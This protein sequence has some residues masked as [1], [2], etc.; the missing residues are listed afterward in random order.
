MLTWNEMLCEGP[1]EYEIGTP[2][3]EEK[4]ANFLKESF[5]VAKQYYHEK[6]IAELTKLKDLSSYDEIN[7]WFEYDLFCHVNMIAAI[8]HLKQL[9]YQ[10]SLFLISSRRVDK[11]GDIQ[12]LSQLNKKQLLEQYAHKISLTLDDVEHANTLWK[13]YNGDDH[14]QF[15]KYLT[16]SSSFPY[17]TNCISAHLK[18]F[19][20]THNGLNLLEVHTLNMIEQRQIKSKHHLLG[21][22]LKY[23]GYYGFG[24][25]QLKAMINK[26]DFLFAIEGD[27]LTLNKKG[28][29]ALEKQGNFFKELK[30]D[31]QFG[32]S[33]KY[34]YVYDINDRVLNKNKN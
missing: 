33:K 34:N 2:T 29:R 19:P 7:L 25:I 4:R 20:S 28:K 5:D 10:K 26:L 8:S 15:K 3:F 18:R 12:G 13:I 32:G 27:Y 24:D 1:T 14:Q 23:Q 11:E 16:K 17:L 31:S 22:M 21:Y 30:D 9:T 6:F